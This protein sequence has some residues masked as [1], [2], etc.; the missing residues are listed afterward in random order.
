MKLWRIAG[1]VGVA[2]SLAL[3]IGGSTSS[4][5][6][7]ANPLPA[8]DVRGPY[9]AGFT[10]FPGSLGT[11]LPTQITVWYPR[12]EAG[13]LG[14]TPNP[15]GTPTYPLT[16]LVAPNPTIL[17]PSPLGAVADASAA[18]GSFPLLVWAHGGP[19]SASNRERQRL[20][21]LE[22][23]EHLATH[24]FIAAS[25]ERNT[26]NTC[27]NEL[28]APRLV[29]D[30][31]L[32]RNTTAGDL[33]EGRID[34][35]KIGAMAHSA[36]GAAAY[37][38]LT[39]ASAVSLPPDPRVKALAVTEATHNICGITLAD[40]ASVTS[41]FMAMGGS[42][43]FFDASAR[44][45][46]ED[47]SNASTRIL[48]KTMTKASPSNLNADHTSFQVG[49]CELTD[50]FRE[51]S[52][53]QQ[54]A[55]GQLPLVEPLRSLFPSDPSI[56]DPAARVLA[57]QALF[58]WNGPV[59]FLRQRSVCNR[60]GTNPSGILPLGVPSADGLVTSAPPYEPVVTLP[61]FT[62]CSPVLCITQDRMDRIVK[63][64]TV[65]F[66][67]ALLARDG[68]YNRFFTPGSTKGEPDAT[69]TR[70]DIP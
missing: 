48:V 23:M 64:Y 68:R 50:A 62:A 55:S 46:F 17:A 61:S 36:G 10:T 67:K 52:L 70:I 53:V 7:A 43:E 31:I 63:L 8:P 28:A 54:L 3:V 29:L 4:V 1:A 12:C 15:P 22:L 2:V 41:P 60:V 5:S 58:Q 65:S 69:V 51:A 21:D 13:R 25:Y 37:A 66:F 27:A 40:K 56:V 42:P 38:L 32:A 45:P 6:L 9:E 19:A 35:A 30:Q 18:Q 49:D 11:G 44:E 39:G 47:M 59:Q 34:V 57:S 16:L 26:A 24:G 33:L 14:C 20:G